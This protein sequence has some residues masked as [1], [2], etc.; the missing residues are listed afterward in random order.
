[1]WSFY[2][3]VPFRT[4]MIRQGFL[5]SMTRRVGTFQLSSFRLTMAMVSESHHHN[6][7]HA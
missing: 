6:L 1:M 4:V 5:L 2:R 7:D 3:I